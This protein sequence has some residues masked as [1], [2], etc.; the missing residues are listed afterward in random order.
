MSSRLL[1]RPR[2]WS[3]CN[4][5]FVH[6]LFYFFLTVIIIWA[7]HKLA[8]SGK[9][10]NYYWLGAAAIILSGIPILIYFFIGRPL[11]PE[12]YH[13]ADIEYT[14]CY[15]EGDKYNRSVTLDAGN[16]KYSIFYWLWHEEYKDEDIVNALSKSS[17]AR[18]WLISND[19]TKIKG[20]QTA[21]FRI[22][23][24]KGYEWDNTNRNSL[25]WISA[26]LSSLGLLII[27]AVRLSRAPTSQL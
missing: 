17:Q 16:K 23:P 22:D 8:S 19:D 3:E 13:V 18:I 11:P 26:I 5:I 9:K 21:Y 25:L 12:K 10:S 2:G 27:V 1:P 14:A 7:T 4:M 20:I 6:S 15:L 24:S